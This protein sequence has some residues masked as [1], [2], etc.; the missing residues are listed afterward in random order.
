MKII[1]QA[2]DI[3]EAYIVAGLLNTNGIETHVGGL[4]LQGGIGLLPATDFVNVHV[5][6]ESDLDAAMV[7]M[8]EYTHTEQTVNKDDSSSYKSNRN[9]SKPFIVVFVALVVVLTFL[10][11]SIS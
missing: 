3:T 10:L 11:L 9:R 7:I 2:A 1:Y 8:D 4:Y 6:N 5:L